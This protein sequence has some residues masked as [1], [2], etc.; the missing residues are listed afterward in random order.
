MCQAYEAEWAFCT[1]MEQQQPVCWRCELLGRWE[2]ATWVWG[3]NMCSRCDGEW[4]AEN[5]RLFEEFEARE[6][7]RLHADPTAFD[8]RAHQE[9]RSAYYRTLWDCTLRRAPSAVRPPIRQFD[10]ARP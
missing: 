7:E 8:R 9:A 3:R 1:H 10:L 4:C 2:R 6:M 5:H